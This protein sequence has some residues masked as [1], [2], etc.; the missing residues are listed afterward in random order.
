MQ[1]ESDDDWLTTG[2]AAALA[3]VSRWTIIRAAEKGDLPHSTVPGG[4]DRRYRR[5][6]VKAYAGTSVVG[7][8]AQL[9]DHEQRIKA[10]EEQLRDGHS[11][12]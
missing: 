7:L 9:D 11:S 6:D 4:R 5:G 1:P 10:I 12:T 8:Q 3:G 2:Q